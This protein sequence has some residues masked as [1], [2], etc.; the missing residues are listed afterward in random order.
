MDPDAAPALSIEELNRLQELVAS[1]LPFGDSTYVLRH[2]RKCLMARLERAAS[3]YISAS[4]LL[5][6]TAGHDE[7]HLDL[8][9]ADT[10][11]RCAIVQAHEE[12]AA[13]RREVIPTIDCDAIFA[14]AARFLES[15]STFRSPI[16]DG[17][18]QPIGQGRHHGLVWSA[19]HAND[20]FGRSFRTLI[21]RQYGALPIAPSE[22][23][24][25][26]LRIGA[27]LLDELLPDL[28]PSAMAHA[29]IVTIVPSAGSFT[30][31]G[32]SSQ[33]HLGGVVFLSDHVDNP[34]WVAEHLL[35][36]A[37]HQ[38]L[39]DFR[40]AHS[41]VHLG[42]AEGGNRPV[43]TP[44]NA[45]RLLGK[46]RWNE[47]RVFAGFHVYVHL[48][49]LSLIAQTRAEELVDQYG[50]FQ[51]MI[52]S[53]RAASRASYLET[54]LRESCWDKLDSGGRAMLEWLGR[55]LSVVNP[56][57]NGMG[58]VL[59]HALDL[60]RREA[61]GLQRSL[62]SPFEAVEDVSALDALALED[63]AETRAILQDLGAPVEM[64]RLDERLNS[65]G[66]GMHARAYP[67]IR[68]LIADSLES[69]TIDGYWLSADGSIDARACAMIER[70]SDQLHAL[71]TRIPSVVAEAMRRVVATDFRQPSDDVVGRLLAIL[72]SNLPVGARVLEIGTGVGLGT[73]WACSG[74][75][76]RDDVEVVTI[77]SDPDLYEVTANY[78]WPSFVTLM[79]GD[80]ELLL[81][82]LGEFDLVFADASP[83]KLHHHPELIRL[84]RAGG[85][86]LFDDIKP[87]TGDHPDPDVSALRLALLN[88][89][90]LRAVELECASGIVVA[91]R[92]A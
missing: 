49:I 16:Q 89:P 75:R 61:L 84:L 64:K 38:K 6:A 59:T 53:R 15:A 1:Q 80:A 85:C 3:R 32:S 77:E 9:F 24:L 35:H 69:S 30:G 21:T 47:L 23:Q 74:L 62:G 83:Y 39:Y 60:Y 13:E 27:E 42:Y 31:V 8:L 25:E 45:S 65:D 81:S 87:G 68:S 2:L 22:T 14:A 41:L 92:L 54:Q 17:S 34:W 67:F 91:T 52:H 71:S 82:T 4:D 28:G 37:L 29:Q 26:Q 86:M 79:Q 56:D 76:T 7:D 88:D 20:T 72:A 40:H 33:F 11:L 48:V 36:E 73:A 12:T 58:S 10:T 43:A 44:W 66:T 57:P 46:N 90:S 50:P 78:P 51:G 70:S 19:D 18:L 63:L 5:A 55:V